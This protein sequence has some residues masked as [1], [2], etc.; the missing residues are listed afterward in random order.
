MKSNLFSNWWSFTVS[1]IIALLYALLAFYNPGELSKIIGFFG[2]IILIAG[3]AML[4]GTISNIKNKQPYAADLIWS[5]LTIAA[6]GILTFYTTQAVK[7]FVII[8]GIWAILIGAIQF[9]I[10]TKLDTE[11]KSRNTFLI[12]GIITIVFG[13]ILF[14]NPFQA[15]KFL[16]LLT[17][18]LSFII[19]ILLIALSIKMK[20]LSKDAQS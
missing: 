13:V 20:S 1:G 6:G 3:I 14:F 10:M 7:I 4:I 11:D 8:V 19:G 16:L 18:V 5:I 15:A 2:I 12:S 9:Y 17:G